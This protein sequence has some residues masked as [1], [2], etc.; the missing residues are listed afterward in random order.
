MASDGLRHLLYAATACAK[1]AIAF[2]PFL[3]AQVR[4]LVKVSGLE[5]VISPNGHGPADQA[6]GQS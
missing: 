3:S 4:R 2:E 5:T 1:G 6:D